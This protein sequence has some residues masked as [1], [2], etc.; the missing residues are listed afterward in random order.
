MP[1]ETRRPESRLSFEV[2]YPRR[3]R[4][5]KSS[6]VA[7]SLPERVVQ[8]GTS[9]INSRPRLPQAADPKLQTMRFFPYEEVNLAMLTVHVPKFDALF[10]VAWRR[11]FLATRLRTE[12]QR[13]VP[14]VSSPQRASGILASSH[15]VRARCRI[16]FRASL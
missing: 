11:P 2:I 10:S 14:N 4:K 7:A 9:E 13:Q 1:S 5:A 6:P 12:K 15:W 3:V 8:T 16:G